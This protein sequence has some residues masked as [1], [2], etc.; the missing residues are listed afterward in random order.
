M[1]RSTSRNRSAFTLVELP[2]VSRKRTAFTLVELLVVIA[3]IGILVALLL[4]AIQAAR[5]AAR[6]SQC[7]NNMRQIG[8]AISN[9]ESARKTYPVGAAQ[10]YGN[11][12]T[13]GQPYKDDPT[14]YSW[15]SL[16]MPYV[17]EAALYGQVD[18]KI[19]LGVRNDKGDKSHQI[20][21]ETFLCPSSQRV[22]IANSWYGARG[23][24]AGNVGIGLIWMNDPS[25]FQDCSLSNQ[26]SCAS[27]KANWPTAEKNPER[28]DS[29]LKRFGTFM[30]NKGRKMGEFA[31]GTSKTA[32]V[33][34]IRTVEGQDTRGVLHFGA[35]VLYMHDYPP[36]FTNGVSDRTRWCLNV[37]EAPCL[38]VQTGNYAG[39][40]RH[41]AR[42]NHTGGVNLMMVDTSTRFVADSI[43]EDL[44]KA[45]A[46]PKGDEVQAEGI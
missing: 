29:W 30:V 20:E 9:Y 35:G 38:D 25:P 33:S 2:A 7:L 40:W 4:P 22:G 41:L 42:S 5:E 34:E 44:W 6:R 31:D 12:P 43:A 26:Y 16:I 23:N 32:A 14:M 46:T 17:E 24:Y 11:D 37:K 45:I 1:H 8:I 21:F 39:G 10:R 36:N 15:V 18:W 3:I 19:P 13:T 28:T 27:P